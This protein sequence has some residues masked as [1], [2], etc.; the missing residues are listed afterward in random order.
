MI[1]RNKYL[2][3]LFTLICLAGLVKQWVE[4]NKSVDNYDLPK[5][6]SGQREVVEARRV[7]RNGD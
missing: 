3:I 6:L 1:F 5:E 2:F 7:S 4:H